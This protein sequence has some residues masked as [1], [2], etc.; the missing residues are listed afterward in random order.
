MTQT[1]DEGNREVGLQTYAVIKLRTQ[2]ICCKINQIC[3]SSSNLVKILYLTFLLSLILI[4]RTSVRRKPCS[5]V[6]RYKRFGKNLLPPNSAQI[7]YSVPTL[8]KEPACCK[9][10]SVPDKMAHQA[11][12]FLMLIKTVFC[13]LFLFT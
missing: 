11:R 6:R 2:Y 9:A 12:S 10:T 13:L 3:I 7:S 4:S 8:Q 5:L 1:A